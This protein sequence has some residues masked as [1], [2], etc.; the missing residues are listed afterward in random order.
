M[1][2]AVAAAFLLAA[3]P[4]A[5]AQAV[6]VSVEELARASDVVLRGSVV[7]A[8][9]RR[10]EDRRRV[11]TWFAVRTAATLRGSAPAL[12][13]VVVPGGVEGD[14]G[15][16]MD[17]APTL[18]VGEDVIVFL[19]RAGPEAFHVTGLAQGK[20]AVAGAAARPDLSQ[21]TFVRTSVRPGERRAEEMPLGELER[22]VRRAR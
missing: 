1:R 5:G 8:T 15:Q 14:L 3:L 21:L 18:A 6:A 16:R 10:S 4:A 12:V 20:F 17:A 2:L 7:S 22:R 19:S 9:P 13:Q 11:L